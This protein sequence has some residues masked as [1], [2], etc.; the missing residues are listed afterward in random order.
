VSADVAWSWKV[1]YD[2]TFAAFSPGVQAFLDLTEALLAD[3]QVVCVDSC[4]VENHPMIDH[5][6]GERLPLGDWLIGLRGGA[7]FAL[8]CRLETAR[9]KLHTLARQLRDATVIAKNR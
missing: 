4:A 1:A 2:E 9:R 6:W 8:A 3:D 5:L 7:T